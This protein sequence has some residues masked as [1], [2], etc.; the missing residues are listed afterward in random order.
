MQPHV[1]MLLSLAE[2]L[3]TTFV[4]AAQTVIPALRIRMDPQHWWRQ[5]EVEQYE[6]EY[7]GIRSG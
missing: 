1:C 2:K 5:G 6:P 4:S 3:L 7:V